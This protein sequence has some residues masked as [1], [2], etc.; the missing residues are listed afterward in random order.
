MP[1]NDVETGDETFFIELT[2]PDETD[3]SGLSDIP[4]EDGIVT[5]E[6]DDISA[7]NKRRLGEYFDR[8]IEDANNPYRPSNVGGGDEYTF[9]DEQKQTLG[10]EQS[11][12]YF[13]EASNS[14]LFD[15]SVNKTTTF[16]PNKVDRSQLYNNINDKLG[17]ADL[18]QKL[19]TI[20]EENNR[21]SEASPYIRNDGTET[22]LNSGTK[23]WIPQQKFGEHTPQKYPDADTQD[24]I[25]VS[26][27]ELKKLGAQILLEA[28]GE[29]INANNTDKLGATSEALIATTTI[30]SLS[31][32]GQR[33]SYARFGA[34][35]IISK[36]NSTFVK[37]SVSSLE[38]DGPEKLSYGA[39]YNPLV[40]FAGVS[41]VASQ[42]AASLLTITVTSMISALAETIKNNQVL[43]LRG[44]DAENFSA[45]GSYYRTARTG[46]GD[47]KSRSSFTAD[48]DFITLYETQAEYK[49]AINKG[50]EVFFDLSAGGISFGASAT[51]FVAGSTTKENQGFYHVLLRNLVRDTG[52]LFLGAA[53]PFAERTLIGELEAGASNFDIDSPDLDSLIT[54]T[55]QLVDRIRNSKLL[56]F[57]NVIARIG[58]IAL[59]SE[60]D[61]DP[62]RSLNPVIQGQEETFGSDV[63]QAVIITQNRLE[64]NRRRTLGFAN[65]TV[66]SMYSLPNAYT[67]AEYD[68]YGTTDLSDQLASDR[69]LYFKKIEGNRIAAEDVA[70]LEAQLD[71]YYCPFYFHDLRTNEIVA[72]HA[73]IETITDNFT[74]DHAETN[75]LGRIGSVM[76]Y[77]NT[78]RSLSLT[79]MA[80]S[81]NP[82]DF[83]E[84]WLKINKLVMMLYP[85]YT[86]GRTVE[87]PENGYKFIQPFSQLI[88]SSPMIRLR[89]GDLIKTNYSKFDLMRLF[90]AGA[91]DFVISQE[92]QE[93]NEAQENKIQSNY[94]AIRAK[95]DDSEQWQPGYEFVIQHDLE[96]YVSN[97]SSGQFTVREV[98]SGLTRSQQRRRDR[99]VN[100][101]VIVPVPAG[102][103]LRLS[104]IPTDGSVYQFTV[105][106]GITRTNST[107][108]TYGIDI[109]NIEWQQL[110][111]PNLEWL[112]TQSRLGVDPVEVNDIES[113]PQ[114]V[115]DFFSATGDNA[116]PVVQGF[117][118]TKGDGLAGFIRSLSFDYTNF[119]WETERAN[120]VAPQGMRITM[121]FAPIN[122]IS[123]GIHSDGF[124]IGGLYNVGAILERVKKTR[125]Q[126]NYKIINRNLARPG[127]REDTSL[128]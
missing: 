46:L 11:V 119:A 78:N 57:M 36:V 120:S 101:G 8:V 88:G 109:G 25:P 97:A 122:D 28:S 60:V 4:L 61:N 72:F 6:Q 43:D 44:Q 73:F 127:D 121:E 92:L 54:D 55:F 80:V 48:D 83:D 58:D 105:V 33:V 67:Q 100:N 70:A 94:S 116:N 15:F 99:D 106:G 74:V 111:T 102:T 24:N 98:P 125:R 20:L 7:N 96:G 114:D 31:R 87:N 3:P 23:D 41:S 21:F 63:N 113:T 51:Q 103:V 95:M 17:Q 30:P 45:F 5:F 77:K 52:D 10:G 35:E 91:N 27:N 26:I 2:T 115:R 16:D 128:Q 112:A 76:S 14:K 59:Y 93:R 82:S 84:M 49:K 71:S 13:E 90:G 47:S 19:D 66:L 62:I 85:Q 89:V 22:E 40:Q 65:N 29:A 56:K 123:P 9:V 69:G 12:R 42:I 124:M 86:Q 107:T 118:S 1:G 108:A 104:A 81:T 39:P 53:A 75:G 34:G 18:P 64:R 110:I 117:E 50:L 37:P 68:S 32:L 126:E 79:F 38:N